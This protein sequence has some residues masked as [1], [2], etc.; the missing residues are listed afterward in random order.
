[1]RRLGVY[2]DNNP[3]KRAQ[4]VVASDFLQAGLIGRFERKFDRAFSVTSPE[5]A[6][7]IFGFQT[8]PG[9]Y[10]WDA[11]NGFF[12]NAAGTAATLHI[13]SH[14]GFDGTDIDGVVASASILNDG[15]DGIID[16]TAAYQTEPE[17]GV[18]G[19]RTGYRIIRGNRF[20]T[21]GAATGAATDTSAELDSVAGISVGDIVRFDLTGGAS[22]TVYKKITGVNEGTR[23][24][25]FDG[26]I[27]ATSNLA[28]GD[29]V[30]V[31]GFRIEVYRKSQTGIETAV[32]TDLAELWLTTEPEVQEHYAANV[33]E[34]SRWIKVDVLSPT[35]AVE[36]MMPVGNASTVYLAGGTDGTSPSTAAHWS[37]ALS[38][39]NNLP[40]RII[41][42][43]ETTSVSVQRAMEVYAK[44]RWDNPKVIVNI[45]EDRNETQLRAIG[46]G[47]Q[48]SDDVLMV[49]V[50]NW[51][52][53]VDPFNTSE[54]A[55]YRNVPNVGH[56]AGAWI[57]SIGTK[58]VH[59]IPSTLDM[60]LRGVEGV[61]GDQFLDD[62]ARTR[63]AD[64][65]VNVIQSIS[66][67][68][69]VIRNFFTPSTDGAFKFANGLLMRDF[70]KVSAVDSLR[71]SENKPNSLDR[72]KGDKTAIYNFMLRLWE[73]GSTGLVVRG[74]T[75][76][77]SFRADGAATT[78]SDHFEVKADPVNNPVSEI[79]AGNR[80]LDVWFTYPAPAGSIRIGVGILLRG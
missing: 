4:S 52:K 41:F 72:I 67:S 36:D 44:N 10:G 38:R 80:N 12:A 56:V 59:Y 13:S 70:I 2:G 49:I 43:P 53:V 29:V 8:L 15:G 7:R 45:A 39:M 18:S 68:G 1:M 77:Q 60:G 3:T 22:A 30:T 6:Q 31:P 11:V 9:T 34:G 23:E 19:N 17:F 61:V 71:A 50:A 24:V 75:F 73:A 20:E 46:Q 69:V 42:N 21:A 27:H 16:I 55:P 65:G 66:G 28:I 74:E 54:I 76:G 40:V 14:V 63:V 35:S 62:H 57:R 32:D 48:R 64:A 78:A 51:L 33:F 25:T 5:E 58:G 79:E 26:V 47:F 37:R